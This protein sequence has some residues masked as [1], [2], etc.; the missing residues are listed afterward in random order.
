MKEG[1]KHGMYSALYVRLNISVYEWH[2]FHSWAR[3][4]DE[5]APISLAEF[6]NSFALSRSPLV[7]LGAWWSILDPWKDSALQKH[8]AGKGTARQA[9]GVYGSTGPAHTTTGTKIHLEFGKTASS[10]QTLLCHHLFMLT[11][12]CDLVGSSLCS[13]YLTLIWCWGCGWGNPLK[14][15]R[16]MKRCP[17]QTVA[18]GC[19]SP[20][21]GAYQ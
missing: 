10:H 17:S 4:N 3:E 2:A 20:H 16:E 21:E 6:P 19:S 18:H 13:Y 5:S 12:R 1:K 9:G 8:R 14:H 11:R 15:H 7:A